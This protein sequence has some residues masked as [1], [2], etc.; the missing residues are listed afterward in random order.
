[1]GELTRRAVC[2]IELASHSR[3]I[4]IAPAWLFGYLPICRTAA[5]LHCRSLWS[6]N[7][8]GDAV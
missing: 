2:C 1:M 7:I 6:L 4:A 8:T 3:H 5:L